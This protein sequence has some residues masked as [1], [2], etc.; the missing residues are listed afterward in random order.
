MPISKITHVSLFKVISRKNFFFISIMMGLIRLVSQSEE[1]LFLLAV[2]F[3]SNTDNLHLN[4]FV[5]I[6]EKNGL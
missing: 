2:C 6:F 3:G 4:W 5:Q 1:M